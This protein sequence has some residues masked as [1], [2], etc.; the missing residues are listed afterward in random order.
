MAADLVS[1]RVA[2][3]F[4]AGSDVATRAAIAATKTIPIVFV[5]ASDPV[6]AGFV[7]SF[8]RPEGN[9]T[10]I[11]FQSVELIAKRLELLREVLPNATRIALLVNPGNPGVM[12]SNIQESQAA[13]RRLGVEMVVLEAATENAIEN[14]MATAVLQGA[15]A[16]VIGTDAYI[17]SYSRQIAFF[18][19]RHGMPTMG[20][21]R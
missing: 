14:S 11:T 6:A 12:Q 15:N 1:R 20:L 19:L 3:I 8:A 10:G 9:V 18:A 16:L 13:A 4:A 21:S 7:A 5:T 17:Q 2:V